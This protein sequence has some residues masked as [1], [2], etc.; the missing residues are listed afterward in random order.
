MS[1]IKQLIEEY[2]S[3]KSLRE[4]SQEYDLNPTTLR[5]HLIKAG[6][7]LRN[8]EQAAE[9]AMERGKITSPVINR[10]RTQEEKDLISATRKKKWQEMSQDDLDKFR[11]SAKD[12]W[13]SQSE[14]ERI[15]KQQKAGE[16]LRRASIEGSKAEK[17][18]YKELS[19]GGYDVI[20]HKKGL[21]PGE[22][23]EI[24]LFLPALMVAIEIDGPQHFLP[25]YGEDNL[26]RNIKYDA[27]KNGALLSRGVCVIR[28]KYLSKHNSAIINKKIAD[29]V[30]EQLKRIELK[31]PDLENRLIELEI[32][33][34]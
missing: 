3:G 14:E 11:K 17:A 12:R 25:I 33:N 7:T 20:I 1:N 10:K 19:K 31:F 16:A 24:D 28:I 26:N 32:E 5:R 29:L 4:I 13:D 22:K 8:K 2:N 15:Y 6:L 9:I 18:L 23:Y 27:I 34:V 30:L 21:I